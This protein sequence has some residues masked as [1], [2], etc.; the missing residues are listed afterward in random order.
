MLKIVC[1]LSVSCIY[2]SCAF[3]FFHGLFSLLY[4]SS[5]TDVLYMKTTQMKYWYCYI[6][7]Q[8]QISQAL[9]LS[10][11]MTEASLKLWL[12]FVLSS[13]KSTQTHLQRRR[14]HKTTSASAIKRVRAKT[15]AVLLGSLKCVKQT[16]W[17]NVILPCVS[18][19]RRSVKSLFLLVIGCKL[20]RKW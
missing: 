18:K 15:C 11:K 16:H 1:A 10:Y 14:R 8:T 13:G 3:G 5:A 9:I 17:H 12:V 20:L 2:L 6:R 7:S 19:C 4:N